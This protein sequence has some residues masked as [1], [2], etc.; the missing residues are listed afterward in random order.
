MDDDQLGPLASPERLPLIMGA[1][2]VAYERMTYLTP[3]SRGHDE[4]A[5]DVDRLR[6][7][8]LLLAD[9]LVPTTLDPDDDLMDIVRRYLA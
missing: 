7:E 6:S 8:Y 5:D 3:G 4:A 1:W 2:K 9:G